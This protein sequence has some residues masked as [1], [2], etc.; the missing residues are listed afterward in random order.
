M[1]PRVFKRGRSWHAECCGGQWFTI[2]RRRM[3]WDRALDLSL[4]HFAAYH[5]HDSEVPS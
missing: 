2:V 5:A 3:T 4:A 1:K